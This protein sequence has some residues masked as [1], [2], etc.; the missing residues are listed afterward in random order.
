MGNHRGMSQ[1]ERGRTVAARGATGRCHGRPAATGNG[2]ARWRARPTRRPAPTGGRA[3]TRSMPASART[4]AADGPDQGAAPPPPGFFFFFFRNFGRG[5]GRSCQH[6]ERLEDDALRPAASNGRRCRRPARGWPRSARLG[7]AVGV[8]APAVHSRIQPGAVPRR[9]AKIVTSRRAAPCRRA[10]AAQRRPSWRSGARG[11]GPRSARRRGSGGVSCAKARAIRTRACSPPT[12]S[13]PRA[14]RTAQI[15]GG[16]RPAQRRR[17]RRAGALAAARVA[18]GG[19]AL[20]A[21]PPRRA[22]R[23]RAPVANHAAL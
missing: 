22:R 10:P 2:L 3:S 1:P 14:A 9:K 8:D 6:L 16:Q 5:Q 15:H 19:R 12:I 13:W 17:G 21:F 7:R 4:N 11:R 20:R 23:S 18:A